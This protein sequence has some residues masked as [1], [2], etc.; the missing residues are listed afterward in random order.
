MM[1]STPVVSVVMPVHNGEQFLRESIESILGQTLGDFE[2][3]VINDG[4]TD[5]SPDIIAEYAKLDNRLRVLTNEVKSGITQAQN[6]GLAAARGEYIARQDDDD[7]SYSTRFEYQIKE[8]RQFPQIAVLGCF[9]RRIDGNEQFLS[10]DD[11]VI[12][13]VDLALELLFRNWMWGQSQ[14]MLRARVIHD[15]GGYRARPHAE[16]YDLLQRVSLVGHITRLP[17][18]LVV[19]RRHTGSIT[20]VHSELQQQTAADVSYDG[21]ARLL[22]D[23][24]RT[25]HAAARDLI[26][27]NGES[28][29]DPARAHAFQRRLG[30]AFRNAAAS[31]YGERR[32]RAATAT[33]FARGW[34]RTLRRT[35]RLSCVMPTAL[36]HS[37]DLA[38]RVVDRLGS[39]DASQLWQRLET[40]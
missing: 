35:R 2:L 20:H 7:V 33:F 40:R 17:V 18:E 26:L 16:D 3:I 14:L 6:L 10:V 19:V 4:S 9:T 27:G 31:V 25:D 28:I 5:G 22:G 15:L 8:L 11:R 36:W 12:S 37:A 29:R 38:G 34:R 24:S 32:I 30:R 21:M 39:D 1:D 23:V 13:S